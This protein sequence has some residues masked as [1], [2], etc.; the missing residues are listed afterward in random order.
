MGSLIKKGLL[1]LS[2]VMVLV[3][4]GCSTIQRPSYLDRNSTAS[5]VSFSFSP[6]GEKTTSVDETNAAILKS[7]KKAASSETL[8]LYVNYETTA[9]AVVDKRNGA[10]WYTTMPNASKDNLATSEMKKLMQSTLKVTYQSGFDNGVMDSYNYSIANGQFQIEAIDKGVKINYTIQEGTLDFSDL[11]QKINDTRFKQFFMNN[12][13]LNEADKV[14]IAKYF[15]YD[16]TIGAWVMTSTKTATINILYDIMQR[17]GYTADEL[18]KDNNEFGIVSDGTNKI[19]FTIPLVLTIDNDSLMAEISLSEMTYNEDNPPLVITVLPYLCSSLSGTEGYMFVPD[20]SGA[21]IN[22]PE[23]TTDTGSYSTKMY[24]NNLTIPERTQP[25]LLEQTVMPVY[26]I[27]TGHNSGLF[28]IIEEGESLSKITAVKSGT[29][30]SYN[31]IYSS[32]QY[33]DIDSVYIGDGAMQ[34]NVKSLQK[35]PY[36]GSLKIRYLALSGENSGYVGMAKAYRS[37]LSETANLTKLD[38]AEYSPFN[39]QL[40]G[41]VDNVDSFLGFSYKGTEGLTK[42]AEVSEIYDDLL[43]SGIHNISI[44]Y[45]GWFNGGLRQDSA[46]VIKTISKLGGKNDFKNLIAD[47]K[48]KGVL[49]YPDVSFITVPDD[50]GNFSHSDYGAKT[51]DGTTARKYDYDIVTKDI[52]DRL[53]IVSPKYT[54]TMVSSFLKRFTKDFSGQLLCAGDLGNSIYSDYNSKDSYS[55]EDAETTVMNA[56][57]T[58][59]KTT[60]G[61][62]LVNPIANAAALADVIVEAPLESNGY[63]IISQSVPFYSIVM[64]GSVNF[65]GDAYNGVSDKQYYKL[66]IIESGATPYFSLMS[67]QSSVLKDSNYSY[68]LSHTYDLWR[69]DLISMY[70]E[71]SPMLESIYNSYI[72]DHRMLADNV[73]VTEYE[74]G[75]LV[76]VNYSGNDYSENGLTVKANDYLFIEG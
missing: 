41:A 43:S 70:K 61:M 30:N 7:Y 24:G 3:I 42:Y 38:A 37:Y 14:R 50:S 22:F 49:L 65:S 2:L 12:E 75:D 23:D 45:S 15:E 51:L 52:S 58:V 68:L 19:F 62:M 63:K 69:E 76:Y 16:Q 6:K 35:D 26:G 29:D 27:Y 60:E 59:N 18:A 5:H 74:N 55:R 13:A 73:Y 33:T 9:A 28:A 34:T 20:G 39:L 47:A 72:Y 17:V 48:N 8:D 40:L 32:F 66:K 46:K 53:T 36:D 11:V 44:R 1:P 25:L 21:I 56:L 54:D 57:A 64:H 71:L 31:Y 67:A 10:V 4:S